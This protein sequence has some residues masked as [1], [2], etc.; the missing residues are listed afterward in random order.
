MPTPH[1][2]TRQIRDG[3]QVLVPDVGRHSIVRACARV[4]G[5]S[6]ELT[7]MLLCTSLVFSKRTCVAFGPGTPANTIH[8]AGNFDVS[9]MRAR[10]NSV[11]ER[12][13]G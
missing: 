1:V 7:Y 5:A 2:A 12:R 11:E 10:E 4:I 8:I 3:A 9:R 13:I 6:P